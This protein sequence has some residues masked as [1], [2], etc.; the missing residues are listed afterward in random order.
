[1]ELTRF[2]TARLGKTVYDVED[3]TVRA[4]AREIFERLTWRLGPGDR[5][6]IVGANG[7]GKT[8]LLRLLGG[9]VTPESGP[10]VQ[11]KTR[12][13]AHLYRELVELDRTRRVLESVEEIKQRI[14]VGKRDFTA[15]Q[16]LER[17]GFRSDAQWTP[18]GDLSGGERRR[19]Q[20]LR[21]LM[22]EPNV[23][24]LDEPTNDLDIEMLTEFE[25][26]LD[27]WSGT[28]VVVSHDR[29]FLERV[30]DAVAA[31]LGDG[32]IA[33]LPGGVDD[34]LDR[35]RARRGR[36]TA[37][38]RSGSSSA[39]AGAAT[40]GD[41]A[42]A[43]VGLAPG[44][45]AERAARKELQRLERQIERASARETALNSELAANATD[46]EKLTELGAQLR[47]VQA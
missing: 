43:G 9:S 12:Q 37:A 5:V 26:L 2:A 29:Y 6:G 1:V 34:Y 27:G 44:S 18:V 42:T 40:N 15:G 3:V 33:F 35:V 16:L 25:D 10:V 21:L 19:L 24:L 8:T 39:T 17:L 47:V 20:L 13:L 30:T 46:Y 28:L 36:S 22:S 38:V 23:L 7:S 14:T 31:L 32:K 4:G 11:G 45:A 41:R